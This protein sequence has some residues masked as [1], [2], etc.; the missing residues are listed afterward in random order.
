MDGL[1]MSDQITSGMNGTY[2]INLDTSDGHGTH[3]CCMMTTNDNYYLYFDPLGFPPLDEIIEEYNVIYSSNQ[4]QN[5]KSILCGYYVCYWLYYMD[6]NKKNVQTFLDFITKEFSYD[7]MANQAKLK[8]L[9][10]L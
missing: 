1:V 5:E 2:M 7:T 10:H 9:L 6:K 4:I 8:Q 3:W